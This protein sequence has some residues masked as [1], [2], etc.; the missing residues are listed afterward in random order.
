MPPSFSPLQFMEFSHY[1]R[2]KAWMYVSAVLICSIIG[3]A[4]AEAATL[5]WR[6]NY[7]SNTA[8]D[9]EDPVNW[10]TT[11]GGDSDTPTAPSSTDTAVLY[12]SR[13]GST[14]VFHSNARVQGLVINKLYTGSVL[15]GTGAIQVGSAGIRMGSGTLI[16]GTGGL[17]INGG[18]F[19]MTGGVVKLPNNTRTPYTKLILSGS[20]ALSKGTGASYTKFVSTGSIVFDGAANQNFTVAAASTTFVRTFRN[21]T[22]ENT[23]SAG[24]NNIIVSGSPLFLSGALTITQ[25]NLNL[26]TNDV[27]LYVESG[28][29]IGN[30]ALATLST[31]ANLT[32]SGHIVVGA[33][34]VFT[35]SGTS[36]LTLN[37]KSQNLDTNNN[38]LYNLTIGSSVG[39]TLTSN[40]SV[41]NILQINTGST[42]S[43][44][45]YTV[46][47]TGTTII[48]YGT[49]SEGTGKLKHNATVNITDSSYAADN[50]VVPGNIYFSVADSDENID[51]TTA[52]TISVTVSDSGGDS[53]SVTLTET[54]N[55]SGVFH[56]S[57]LASSGVN[58]VA[59]DGIL[60][61]TAD[62]TVTLSN[63]DAQD[64]E[65][66]SDT[67]T[68][69]VTTSSSS[70]STATATHSGGGG[71]RSTVSKAKAMATKPVQPPSPIGGPSPAITPAQQAQLR[72][73]V[74]L[75]KAAD[76]KAR[77][78]ARAAARKAKTK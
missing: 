14:M 26:N 15:L 72:R 74:R 22:L 44:G 73:Q 48:N 42:L 58:Y 17:S 29:T 10:S 55:N 33:A 19:T 56:G 49:I 2:R 20:L 78:A 3:V 37:G 57:I 27:A 59:A 6:G 36:T 61:V 16:G 54:T 40:Q 4:T 50:E 53:E 25:G 46:Y 60:E 18:S 31:D 62:S 28:V 45:T 76:M 65:I 66:A 41:T 71:G 12:L 64:A 5:Y 70:S 75:Q 47:A 51:G 7:I 35:M 67:A 9:F 63:S 69:T 1:F 38:P 23:G 77:A 24:S 21:V 32:A 52:D 68:M 30:N 11:L 39:T 34:G 13:T 8:R 43:L